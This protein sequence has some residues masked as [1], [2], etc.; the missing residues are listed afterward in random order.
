M[1]LAMIG[2]VILGMTLFFYVPLLLTDLLKIENGI[3]FNLIDGLFR[4]I[5]IFL[6]IYTITRWKE[7]QRVFEYHGAEHKAIFTFEAEE[8]LSPEN[9][10]RQSR[11]HPRCGTSFLLTVVLISVVVFVFLGRPDSI[12]EKL[13][14]FAFIPVIGGISYEFLRLAGKF[15]DAAIMRPIIA[16]GLWLQR[17]TT[18]EPDLEQLEVA[19]HALKEVLP[20]AQDA[21]HHRVAAE[22]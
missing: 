9:A 10:A 5:I 4:L 14:R 7:M 11:F 20:D 21:E 15:P 22:L 12:V 2:A 13:I 1:V 19:L 3:A 17:I 8:D 16:P 6:Y 18:R